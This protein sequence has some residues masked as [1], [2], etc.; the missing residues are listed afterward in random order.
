MYR[1]FFSNEILSGKF[2]F[3]Q[4]NAVS[5]LLLEIVTWK[6]FINEKVCEMQPLI[7]ALK[8]TIIFLFYLGYYIFLYLIF[9]HLTDSYQIIANDHVWPQPSGHNIGKVNWADFIRELCWLRA[10]LGMKG[11]LC[12]TNNITKRLFAG[13]V[14]ANS[15]LFAGTIVKLTPLKC[16]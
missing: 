6:Y 11:R 3:C 8:K 1:V 4:K 7:W 12:Y 13:T 16:P 2:F 10:W 5:V 9:H 15:T 14:P